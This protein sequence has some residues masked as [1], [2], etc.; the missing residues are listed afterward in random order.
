METPILVRDTVAPDGPIQPRIDRI[1]NGRD[2]G[3]ISG[4]PRTR[5]DDGFG[6]SRHAVHGIEVEEV[7]RGLMESAAAEWATGMREIQPLAP[8]RIPPARLAVVRGCLIG[9]DRLLTVL[10]RLE[11]GPDVIEARLQSIRPVGGYVVKRGQG[12]GIILDVDLHPP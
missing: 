7:L 8:V 10:Q 2:P 1:G 9:K 11:T 4:V 6:Q 12:S 5:T 3:R